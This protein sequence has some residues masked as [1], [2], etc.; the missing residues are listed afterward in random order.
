MGK[1]ML[2]GK[3]SPKTKNKCCNKTLCS[4]HLLSRKN[5]ILNA[6]S[7]DRFLTRQ[8]A[9][10][11]FCSRL[12]NMQKITEHDLCM[13]WKGLY[14]Y[15][16]HSD[17]IPEQVFSGITL[18]RLVLESRPAASLLY[19]DCF[20]K[21]LRKEW[22]YIGMLR[23][24]KFMMLIRKFTYSMF[25]IFSCNCWS[26]EVI[27]LYLSSLVDNVLIPSIYFYPY[28]NAA[29]LGYHLCDIIISELSSSCY[30]HN[31]RMQ[32]KVLLVLIQPFIQI[33]LVP[34]KAFYILMARCKKRIFDNIVDELL[35]RH[36]NWI[37]QS[38]SRLLLHNLN[39]I[40]LEK[41]ITRHTRRVTN[42]ICSSLKKVLNILRKHNMMSKSLTPY[43]A[44]ESK[45]LTLK[46][47]NASSMT[48]FRIER[49]NF[50]VSDISWNMFLQHYKHTAT[51]HLIFREDQG[52]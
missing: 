32:E 23:L 31:N 1:I 50:P 20:Y 6:L 36:N 39:S 18:A 42:E 27:N 45:K 52:M 46:T 16:W 40:A 5:K 10:L 26:T 43:I 15:Y 2:R 35:P 8:N 14:F 17:T 30:A 12:T 33:F 9:L 34:N 11:D 25:E 38:T 21:I 49:N 3:F 7:S 19:F 24:D 22:S 29:G 37:T 51:S 28:C 4:T 48:S 44:K 13:N 41:G 47:D